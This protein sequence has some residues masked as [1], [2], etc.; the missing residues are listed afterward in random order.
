MLFNVTSRV[1]NDSIR[2]VGDCGALG[3]RARRPHVGYGGLTDGVTELSRRPP[4]RLV[5]A[6]RSSGPR[7][8]RP[9]SQPVTRLYLRRSAVTPRSCFFI[10]LDILTCQFIKSTNCPLVAALHE[11]YCRRTTT[12]RHFSASV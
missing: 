11:K 2:Y 4:E 12:C 6:D 8:R 3:I 10:S 5:G 7:R 1:S 9:P